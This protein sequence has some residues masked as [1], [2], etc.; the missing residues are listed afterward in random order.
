VHPM[1]GLSL[2]V[3]ATLTVH[4]RD[5]NGVVHLAQITHRGLDQFITIS[6]TDYMPL[7][8]HCIPYDDQ[9][10]HVDVH[11]VNAETPPTCLCCVSAR[12]E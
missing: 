6:L 12:D 8:T 10:L 11:W 1:L 7:I 5:K 3:E 4:G 9:H 2:T